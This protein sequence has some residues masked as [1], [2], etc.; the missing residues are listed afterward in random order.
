LKQKEPLAKLAPFDLWLIIHPFSCGIGVLWQLSH[1]L[2]EWQSRQSFGC[3]SA[4]FE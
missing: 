4:V 1:P 3:A 2:T